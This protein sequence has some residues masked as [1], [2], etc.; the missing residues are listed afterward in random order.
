[1]I[2][3]YLTKPT[4][5]SLFKKQRDIIMGN[6]PLT[7]EEHVGRNENSIDE[8]C[9]TVGNQKTRKTTS[10]QMSDFIEE[11]SKGSGRKGR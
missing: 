4:Q 11:E 8:E 5:G 10:M 9:E 2:A 3:D 1:M 7:M 6:A